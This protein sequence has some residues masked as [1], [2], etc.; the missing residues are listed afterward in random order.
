M[1]RTAAQ[2]QVNL[3]SLRN[4]TL[5][6]QPLESPNPES[7]IWGWSGSDFLKSAEDVL[8][9]G[10]LLPFRGIGIPYFALLGLGIK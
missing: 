1:E 10:K 9:G 4:N 7:M 8:L 5:K 2:P 6:F 3:S